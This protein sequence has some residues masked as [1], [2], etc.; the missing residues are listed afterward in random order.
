MPPFPA[1]EVLIACLFQPLRWR[2]YFSFRG[3]VFAF[4]V[5]EVSAKHLCLNLTQED[6]YREGKGGRC[7]EVE[8]RR[9]AHVAS[10]SEPVF[11]QRGS[12]R[13]CAGFSFLLS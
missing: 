10:C 12:C 3:V 2:F 9:A 4:C 13:F 6:E 7:L 5:Q 8:G 1:W 11:R